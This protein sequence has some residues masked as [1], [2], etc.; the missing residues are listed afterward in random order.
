[1]WVSM[2]DVLWLPPFLKLTLPLKIA[3]FSNKFFNTSG[4]FIGRVFI[5]CLSVLY[6]GA[7]NKDNFCHRQHETSFEYEFFFLVITANDGFILSS[8]LW[9]KMYR[10]K[11][12]EVRGGG[13]LN[14]CFEH[15]EV[16]SVEWQ[17]L[18][19]I[20]STCH[21]HLNKHCIVTS[22]GKRCM[23]VTIYRSRICFIIRHLKVFL[24]IALATKTTISFLDWQ[25]FKCTWHF[26]HYNSHAVDA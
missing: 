26:I 1:M 24:F 13:H 16:S 25:Y 19:Y 7:C 12:F 20:P 18:L 10:Q 3:V 5:L 23:H 17:C 21:F 14:I 11:L 2:Y 4:Q 9:V 6:N 15:F 22:S 8:S